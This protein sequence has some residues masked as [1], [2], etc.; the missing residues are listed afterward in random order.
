MAEIVMSVDL[1]ATF[2]K[3]QIG[4]EVKIPLGV[5]TAENIRTA[6]TRFSRENEALRL[7]VSAPQGSTEAT[8][9]CA[10]KDE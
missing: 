7:R 10:S 6:A 5:V 3:M 2:Q 1:K 9:V 4:D 8:V